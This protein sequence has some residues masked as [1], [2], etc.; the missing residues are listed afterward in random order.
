MSHPTSGPE[1][2]KP[3]HPWTRADR[4]RKD[5]A[6]RLIIAYKLARGS[7]ALLLAIAFLLAGP[8]SIE[9][10][11]LAFDHWL[12]EHLTQAWALRVAEF[13]ERV[14]DVHHLHLLGIALL[15]DG[16]LTFTEGWGLHREWWW[17]PWLVVIATGTLLPFE[18][19]AVVHHAEP[20]RIA[21]LAINVAIIAYLARRTARVAPARRDRYH[22]AR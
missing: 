13:L 22:G 7:A 3:P 16:S 8:L 19:V 15:C 14:S 11:L 2:A 21:L 1:S 9:S 12:E 6:L 20:I 18:I 17:A 5:P 10:R 4:V